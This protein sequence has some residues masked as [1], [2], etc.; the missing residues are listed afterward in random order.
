MPTGGR[1]VTFPTAIR[2]GRAMLTHVRVPVCGAV[3]AA[4]KNVEYPLRR[5]VR[6]LPGVDEQGMYNR[7]LFSFR[8]KGRADRSSFPQMS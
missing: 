3:A 6:V 1:K 2:P 8:A 4:T 5:L 7:Y